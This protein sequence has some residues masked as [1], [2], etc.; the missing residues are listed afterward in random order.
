MAS[1]SPGLHLVPWRYQS[2]SVVT[3]ITVPKWYQAG[4]TA[5]ERY[6]WSRYRRGTSLRSVGFS[7]CNSQ[8]GTLGRYQQGSGTT[9]TGTGSTGQADSAFSSFPLQPRHLT[10][11][12]Q[13]QKTYKL[14]FSLPIMMCSARAP[15]TCKSIK[16]NLCTRLNSF[17][18]CY[19]THKTR[20]IDFALTISPFLVFDD[21]TRICNIA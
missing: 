10:T 19:Q 2:G 6:F 1:A 9:A 21:N 7:A 8:S 20:G 14:R 15:C 5:L 4:T 17:K 18:C 11:H 3:R 16:D 13:N 12:T